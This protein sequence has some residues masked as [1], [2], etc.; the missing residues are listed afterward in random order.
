[1]FVLLTSRPGQF[2]T[3][4]TDGMTAVEAYDYVFYGK[5]TA[6]FVIAELAAD[7][8]VRVQEETPPGVVNLVSTRFLEKYATLEAARAALRELASFGTMDI[9]LVPTPLAVGGRS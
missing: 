4:P 6:R 7:T 2:R 8:R 9:A 3:E 1:M 5:R